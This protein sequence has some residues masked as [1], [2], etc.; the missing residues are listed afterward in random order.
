[1][2]RTSTEAEYKSVANNA[3]EL[4]WLCSLLQELGVPQPNPP[5]LWCD[6]IGASYLSVNPVFH[7]RT[8]HVAIDFHFVRELVASKFLEIH[9]VPSSNQIADVL[10][11]PLVTPLLQAQRSF[12]PTELEEGY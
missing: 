12:T 7:A 2:S 1:V 4:L 9:F 8:K 10:T 11:K 5:K 6:N 3:T